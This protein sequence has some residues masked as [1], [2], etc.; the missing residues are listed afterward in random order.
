M[1]L[2]V[3][4]NRGSNCV[5]KFGPFGVYV[6]FVSN[7]V[8]NFETF[9]PEFCVLFVNFVIIVE[10]TP[11]DGSRATSLSNITIES[12]LSNL[13]KDMNNITIKPTGY[14]PHLSN[15]S[16]IINQIP[17]PIPIS[18]ADHHLVENKPISPTGYNKMQTDTNPS[19]RGEPVKTFQQVEDTPVTGFSRNSSMSSLA[20]SNGKKYGN[21]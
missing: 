9:F 5:Q 15:Q 3:W 12:G 17:V 19:S 16:P 20:F 6:N 8:F 4:K 21:S 2:V 11:V 13:T 18:I 14:S 1:K 7:F 10:G